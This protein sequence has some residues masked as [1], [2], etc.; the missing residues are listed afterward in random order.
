MITVYHNLQGVLCPVA[1]VYT[2]SLDYAFSR[3]QHNYS[4][5]TYNENLYA[6]PGTHRSTM[7]GDVLEHDGDRYE[8]TAFGY[9]FMQPVAQ[10]DR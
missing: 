10:W 8:V 7:I 9:R 6:E 5:W 2:D 3:T 4:P 1:K